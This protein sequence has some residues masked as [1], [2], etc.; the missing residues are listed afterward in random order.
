MT[1]QGA[2]PV[3]DD[4]IERLEQLAQNTGKLSWY[5]DKPVSASTVLH[6]AAAEIRNLRAELE[7]RKYDTMHT[8]HAECQ[9][10]ACV[11]RRE[12]DALTAQLARDANPVCGT[13]GDSD[14]D[15]G[16]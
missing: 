12:V 9:R 6:Q 14:G 7:R 4:L 3:S 2:K 16:A 8:C 13:L 11:L 5:N 15:D 1:T 10:D